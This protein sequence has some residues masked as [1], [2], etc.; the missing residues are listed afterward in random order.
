MVQV[1]QQINCGCRRKEGGKAC[2][3]ILL[4]PPAKVARQAAAT[5]YFQHLL[6]SDKEPTSK[7]SEDGFQ[8]IRTPTLPYI[9]A[10]HPKLVLLTQGRKACCVK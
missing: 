1:L 9:T 10:H 8:A 2:A 3:E 5:A 6:P 4:S 7:L